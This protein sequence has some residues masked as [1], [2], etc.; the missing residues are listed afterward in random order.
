[1]NFPNC[2][3]SKDRFQDFLFISGT[4]SADE[5]RM[6]PLK[7]FQPRTKREFQDQDLDETRKKMLWKS[8][9]SSMYLENHRNHIN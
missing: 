8:N 3:T 4:P 9:F 1:M 6:N 5:S 2:A 7:S